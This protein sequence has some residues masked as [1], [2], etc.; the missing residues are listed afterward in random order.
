MAGRQ[1]VRSIGA[2]LRDRHRRPHVR[3]GE[4][5][6]HE[7]QGRVQGPGQ[8]VAE[9]VAEIQAGRVA[10]LAKAEKRLPRDSGLR[11][12][13]RVE[14]DGGGLTLRMLCF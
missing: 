8:G 10:T 14:F 12:I 4:I 9:A 5:V 2:L 11:W 6:A 1:T 3:P 7:Q 13:D